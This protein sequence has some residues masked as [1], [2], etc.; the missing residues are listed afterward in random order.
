M[1]RMSIV[2]TVRMTASHVVGSACSAQSSPCHPASHTTCSHGAVA[3]P[4]QWQRLPQY[5]MPSSTPQQIWLSGEQLGTQCCGGA[6]AAVEFCHGMDGATG[7]DVD[8]EFSLRTAAAAVEFCH[9]MDGDTGVV[10]GG[11]AA[12]GGPLDAMI[13]GAP[14]C[15]RAIH[16]RVCV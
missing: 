3:L 7:I 15:A 12:A 5:A 10:D 11:S 13:S 6:V 8:V 1:K 2:P 4:A 14:F 16:T 9:G